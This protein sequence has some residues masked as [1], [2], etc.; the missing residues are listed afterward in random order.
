MCCF[1]QVLICRNLILCVGG[2]KSSNENKLQ[3]VK[4]CHYQAWEGDSPQHEDS[5]LSIADGI[6]NV[7]SWE[8]RLDMLAARVARIEALVLGLEARLLFL[9]RALRLVTITFLLTLVYAIIK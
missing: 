4:M 7:A 5:L 9:R 2:K 8:R 6:D 3:Q 1:V